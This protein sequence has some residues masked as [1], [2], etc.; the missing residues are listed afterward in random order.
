M[1]TVI[2]WL[3]DSL[4]A[5]SIVMM[6]VMLIRGVILRKMPRRYA[7]LLWAVVAIR[8][9]CPVSIES[10]LSVFNYV[11]EVKLVQKHSAQSDTITS[12]DMDSKSDTI[13][14]GQTS[15]F[16]EAYRADGM[17]TKHAGDA[18]FAGN[19]DP[20]ENKESALSDQETREE[21]STQEDGHRESVTEK[22]AI[23]PSITQETATDA[24][25]VAPLMLI[26]FLLWALGVGV[27][28]M[29]NVIDG[30]K[31]HKRLRTAVR[32]EKGVYESDMIDTPFVKG[33]IRPRIYIPFRLSEQERAC[34]LAHEKHHI[35]RGDPIFKLFATVLLAVFWFHPLVWVS[36][37]LMVRDMEMSC[38]EYVLTHEANDIRASYSTLL[39]AFATNRRIVDGVLFFGENDTKQ[40]VKHVLGFKKKHMALGLIAI[41]VVVLTSACT[42]TGRAAGESLKTNDISDG[43]AVSGQAVSGE[44]VSGESTDMLLSNKQNSMNE[45]DTDTKNNTDVPLSADEIKDKYREYFDNR[46]GEITVSGIDYWTPEMD[47]VHN[48]DIDIDLGKL[49]VYCYYDINEDGMPEMIIS[50]G[51]HRFEGGG[52]SPYT[53]LICSYKSGKVV[54]VFGI[55]GIRGE[56]YR[57]EGKGICAFFGGSDFGEYVFYRMTDDGFEYEERYY[58]LGMHHDDSVMKKKCKYY[59]KSDHGEKISKEKFNE[60]VDSLYGHELMQNVHRSSRYTEEDINSAIKVV[61]GIFKDMESE[62]D[63]FRLYQLYYSGDGYSEDF[64]DWADRNNA[65]EVIV[66]MSEFYVGDS[67]NTTLNDDFTYEDFN[68]ILVRK[69][70]EDWVKVDQGY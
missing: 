13:S 39:L 15:P 31:L 24:A 28:I 33:I 48:N 36:Y 23:F 41:L 62:V 49:S 8:L 35:H 59:N 3:A 16:S 25:G 69:K 44:A 50:D 42:L 10:P 60:V 32:L 29:K 63:D 6:I 68:W 4:V 9:V 37:R 43:E 1:S 53:L 67:K 27:F 19:M 7:Y 2:E 47:V 12:S 58:M 56:A 20:D 54:P 14:N 17:E 11:P 52:I 22:T 21:T 64:S 65:D 45:V 57:W 30:V 26:L 5:G 40:R 70:G 34:I 46:H 61:K 18:V 51:D 55:I 38:D 66:L